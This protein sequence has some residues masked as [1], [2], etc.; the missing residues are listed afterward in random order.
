MIPKFFS[1]VLLILLGIFFVFSSESFAGSPK[2][3]NSRGYTI[4]AK[5]AVLS[6]SN[7]GRRLY[8]KNIHTKILPASTVKVM[9]ALLVLEKLPLDKIITV[10]KSATYVQPSKIYAREG[11]RYTVSDLLYAIL[12]SSANDAS[13]VLAQDVAGSEKEFVRL[14]NIRARQLGA[15]HTLFANAHGLPTKKGSQYTTA[16]DMNLIFRQAL[17]HDFFK[18]ALKQ[19]TKTISSQDGRIIQLKSHNQLLFKSWGRKI[20]G[21]TGYTKAARSC[22]VGYVQ[23][24]K[25]TLIV[26]VF[27]CVKRWD[28]IRYIISKYGGIAL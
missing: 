19:P 5:A 27:G 9:T 23:K 8:G 10:G 24:G 4:S 26:A 1:R 25:S 14:M 11:E 18:E 6:E 20:F 16:Y 7:R 15:R 22:F 12:M 13:I 21:K 2:K 3:K 28:D 17:K